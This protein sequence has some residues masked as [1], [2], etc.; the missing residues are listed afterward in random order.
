MVVLY[1]IL[2][3]GLITVPAEHAF[4]AFIFTL[5]LYL[6][7][8]YITS[9]LANLLGRSALLWVL[10]A[11]VVPVLPLIALSRLEQQD[12]GHFTPEESAAE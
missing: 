7:S 2:S 5:A 8:I 6:I 1:T 4:K 11:I 10:L 9:R 12:C 3:L